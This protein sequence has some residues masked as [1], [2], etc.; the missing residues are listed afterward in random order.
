MVDERPEVDAYLT[1]SNFAEVAAA[2]S[3]GRHFSW[4]TS[5]ATVIAVIALGQPE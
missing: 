5:L 3:L 2:P 4:K 1:P